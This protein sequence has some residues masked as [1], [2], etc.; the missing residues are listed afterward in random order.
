MKRRSLKLGASILAAA[1]PFAASLGEIRAEVNWGPVFELQTLTDLD[2]SGTNIRA[3]NGGYDSVTVGG[4]LFNPF[5]GIQAGEV[6]GQP[7]GQN[8]TAAG[9]INSF[10]GEAG[11]YSPDTGD[12]NL[13]T[14][15]DTHLWTDAAVDMT[16]TLTDL[17]PGQ[18]YRVQIVA[19]A[20]DR[21]VSNLRDRFRTVDAT[22]VIPHFGDVDGDGQRHVTTVIGTF[23]AT[24]ATADIVTSGPWG[25]GW[26]AL[27]V[28]EISDPA[29]LLYLLNVGTS[30]I[31]GTSAQ[32]NVTL[33]NHGAD[34]TLYWDALD[35]GT[36]SWSHSNP[37]G[38]QVPGTVA[39]AITGLAADTRYYYRFHAINTA[40]DPDVETWSR[41]G[42]SFATA[43]A[44][45]AP[46]DPF[47]EASGKNEIY[48]DWIDNF[49]TETGF[50]IERSPNGIDSWSAVGTTG[51]NVDFFINSGLLPGT[52]YHYRVLAVNGGG[53]S[54]PSDVVSATTDPGSPGISVAAWYRMGDNG[55]GSGNLPL[56]SSGNGRNFTGAINSATITP[57]GGGYNNDAYYTFNGS[58]QGYYDIG[59]D[60]PEDNVGV[61]VW[62][63]TS[64]L[65]QTNRTLFSTGS[66]LDGISIG[67]DAAGGNGWF[68]AVSNVAFVGTVGTGN[69]TAGDWIHL[70]VVRDNG[71]STFYVNGVASG[72]TGANPNNATLTHLAVNAGGLDYFGGDI[73]EARIFTFDPGQFNVS[74]LLYPGTGPADPYG[75][76]AGGFDGL[77]DPSADLDFDGDGL[78]TGIE[79]VVGGDPTANDSAGNAPTFD[80]VTDPDHFLFT[81]R[82]RDAAEA[83]AQTTIVVEYGTDL[84]G[85]RN[86]ADHGVADEVTVDDSTDLGGGFHQVTVAIPR[87]LAVAGSL[88]V[89]LRVEIA[90]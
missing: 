11:I 82:R 61:E 67:Y 24:G 29:D 89:R 78:A 31:T 86:T 63:R 59:Y 69:Y 77:S 6:T 12:A 45:K 33:A 14:L 7:L 56:D 32:A 40:P 76:W 87:T 43:L 15:L 52:T 37:L 58:N 72:T 68:G 27:T 41:A 65:A 9:A 79:W 62:V 60:A 10:G 34:V 30:A 48:I 22:R 19:P 4:V 13:N 66:N 28:A 47:A 70:A 2:L 16:T 46:G 39:G 1:L 81:F 38:A 74:A 55:Q 64:D 88:F 20:D 3:F 21:V 51:A 71:T 54:D 73:A 85:W 5:S 36:G 25:G 42:K 50:I 84:N 8:T 44:G 23:Q 83:D 18:W 35:K 53:I 90:P 26:S 80:N 17:T 75:D 49:N 57:T